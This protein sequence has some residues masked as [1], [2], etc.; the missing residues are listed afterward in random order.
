M[1]IVMKLTNLPSLLQNEE[2]ITWQKVT[3][4]HIIKYYKKVSKLYPDFLSLEIEDVVTTF[5]S[6]D[7]IRT[8]EKNYGV[9]FL[10]S[11]QD[12]PKDKPAI[13]ELT[14][15]ITYDQIVTYKSD[16]VNMTREVLHDR[17]F[18]LPFSTDSF[19]YANDLVKAMNW[20]NLVIVDRIEEGIREEPPQPPQQKSALNIYQALVISASIVFSACLLVLFLLLE[21]SKRGCW[22]YKGNTNM[23][24]DDQREESYSISHSRVQ[25]TQGTSAQISSE[26]G[27]RMEWDRS[28]YNNNGVNNSTGDS[29]AM[30]LSIHSAT[31]HLRKNVVERGRL[32]SKDNNVLTGKGA[33]GIERSLHSKSG[34]RDSYVDFNHDFSPKPSFQMEG[35]YG[36][37]EISPPEIPKQV[38][39]SIRSTSDHSIVT[40]RS[41]SNRPFLPPLPPPQIERH[42]SGELENESVTVLLSEGD[43]NSQRSFPRATSSRRPSSRHTRWV[44]G[45]SEASMTDL[46]FT[47]EPYLSDRIYTGDDFGIPNPNLNDANLL[48]IKSPTETYAARQRLP[49]SF[50]SPLHIPDQEG[51]DTAATDPRR[52]TESPIN[53]LSTMLGLESRPIDNSLV[54]SR[55]GFAIK[56]E[57][58]E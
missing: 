13:P 38:P 45:L 24:V 2:I 50:T 3:R 55:N 10:S 32:G 12:Q 27:L 30:A 6:Q 42:R 28:Y 26:P 57:D 37:P 43:S 8:E 16:E 51:I 44:S 29:Q 25:E 33:H 39:I 52:T 18:V 47:T 17:L 53:S 4:E 48:A 23:V 15:R 5:R 36:S 49:N 20:S 58:I 41:T 11:R 9:N 35:N 40:N 31:S 54:S 34:S 1:G 22:S 7:P 56:V 14:L 21:R 19:D 46:T